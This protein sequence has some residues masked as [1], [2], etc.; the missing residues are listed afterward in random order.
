MSERELKRQVE[1][2][3]LR[4]EEA[5]ETIRAIRTGQ[6]DAVVMSGPEGE[7]L[8]VLQG[9]DEPY[10]IFI[11]TMSEGAATLTANHTIVY[12][13]QSFADML[14]IPH[15]QVMGAS[16]E[17]FVASDQRHR[18][19]SLLDQARSRGVRGEISFIAGDKST[20][21]T[22][23]S[24]SATKLAD[25]PG[26][27]LVAN[28]VTRS[29]LAERLLYLASIVESTDDAIIGEQSD[30]TI[31]SW[32]RGAEILFGYAA[33]EAIGRPISILSPADKAENSANV[34]EQIMDGEKNVRFESE[35][36]RKDGRRVQVA[37]TIS[38]IRNADG[39]FLGVSTI[40][41]DITDRK[42]AEEEIRE[43]N[44]G[45]ER[46]VAERTAGLV[47]ANKELESFSYSASHDL[48]APLR[49]MDGY[50]QIL[51]EDYAD[52]LDIEGN[53]Y[54]HR[55]RAASQ[56]MDQL[57]DGILTL[58][59]T[60][61]REIRRTTV[62]LSAITRTVALGLENANPDRLLQFVIRPGMMVSA[63]D[64]LLRIVIE[65]LLGN[66]C[67]FTSKLSQAR[68]EIGSVDLDGE[69]A[70]FVQ[71]NG[72]GFDMTYAAKLFQPFQRLHTPA[73]FQGTGIGL[74]TAQRV[75]RR[76]GGRLWA[77]GEVDKGATFF[78]TL[79]TS[80]RRSDDK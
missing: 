2:L 32:N 78:F 10:R 65:N 27:C 35:R 22:E 9:A 13:N 30:H 44:A 41:R 42:R 49:A 53:G 38:P 54:L 33:E 26:I 77:K 47:E 40:A 64:N 58:S 6:V 11:E 29:K 19:R 20:V 16:L 60:T 71:D 55:V 23:L 69:T 31:M 70:Y 80:S 57:I 74:A 15:E 18:L 43:L 50:C 79:P 63:D 36:I 61:R 73:E 34:F 21:L 62:D 24:L 72:A 7:R 52:R 56:Q 25:A 5:E 8:F 39:D 37:L 14:K 28:D 1:D 4:L 76:H 46:R 3:R 59:R 66:A 17:D 75:V 68:I 45:L 48:R 12:S 51:L 67:K